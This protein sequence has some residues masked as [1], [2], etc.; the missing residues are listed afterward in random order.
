MNVRWLLAEAGGDDA[1]AVLHH[2]Y[3][4]TERALAVRHVVPV[5]HTLDH[6]ICA[7]PFRDVEHALDGVLVL[8]EQRVL[9]AEASGDAEP[10]RVHVHGDGER[11]ARAV[12]EHVEHRQPE[13]ARPEDDHRL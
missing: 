7:L 1:A 10:K 12:A 13:L 9:G 6:T 2:A 11:G 3:R 4:L 5:A 8:Y